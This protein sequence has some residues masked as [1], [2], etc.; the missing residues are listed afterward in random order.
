MPR[1]R[2]SMKLRRP[3]RYTASLARLELN[4]CFCSL[5]VNSSRDVL[6]GCGELEGGADRAGGEAPGQPVYHGADG[7]DPGAMLGHQ[8]L[9]VEVSKGVDDPRDSRVVEAAQMESADDGVHAGNAGDAHGVA[10]DADDPAMRA[11]CD[12]H[13]AAVAHVGHERLLPDERVLEQLALFL[14]A[15]IARDRLPLLG[16]MHLA[17]EPHALGQRRGLGRE[18]DL[19]LVA[20]DLL[21]GEPA[22][23]DPA[24]AAL[25]PAGTKVIDA[26]VEGQI[27]S[28]AAPPR[29]EEAS[30]PTPVIAVAVGEGERV[31]R[32]RIEGQLAE[33]VVQRL[34]RE[35]E[36]Q[37]YR[38]AVAAPRDLHEMR[39]AVFG[40]QVRHL[41]RYERAVPAGHGVVLAQVVDVIVDDGGDADP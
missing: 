2:Y 31:D 40:A 18:P 3:V 22:T 13:Q 38:E 33:V 30:Q 35:A 1:S 19:D 27:A 20:L 39:E 16:G 24:L 41:A 11:R 9:D 10:A 12:H 23:V 21:A 36:V 17:G 8:V 6:G 15:E 5:I 28:Q 4:S 29:V 34:R 26:T 37:G 14:D 7:F 32:R 25:L